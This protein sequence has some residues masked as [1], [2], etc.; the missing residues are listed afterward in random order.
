MIG[1]L[2]VLPVPLSR[3]LVYRNHVTVKIVYI[4]ALLTKL[5]M[6]HH[7][8]PVY[9]QVY[10]EGE[11]IHAKTSFTEEDPFIGRIVSQRVA[12]PHTAASI[13]RFLSKQENISDHNCTNLYATIFSHSALEDGCYASVETGDGPGSSPQ[14]PMALVISDPPKKTKKE[15]EKIE[16]GERKKKKEAEAKEKKRRKE[17]DKVD[18]EGRKRKK[19][20]EAEDKKRKKEAEKVEAEERKREADEKKRKRKE[21]RATPEVSLTRMSI[22]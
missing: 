3:A 18:A 20:A 7:C 5:I 22:A 13:K 10:S 12:P 9:Y 17:A 15:V 8:P 16:A 2:L 1:T 4:L 19:E 14:Q 11:A 21:E 6:N